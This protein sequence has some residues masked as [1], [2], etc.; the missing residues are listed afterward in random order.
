MAMQASP[1]GCTKEVW[2]TKPLVEPQE[3][4]KLKA[5]D[6]SRDKAP[7]NST[8]LRKQRRDWKSQKASCCISE[9]F[10]KKKNQE[11]SVKLEKR[12]EPSAPPHLLKKYLFIWLCRVLAAACGV[13]SCNMWDPTRDWTWASCVGSR[14]LATGSPREAPWA[15]F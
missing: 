4:T 9:C 11:T 1:V 14:V 2:G 6:L 5:R 12:S 8:R 3:L 15:S 7:Q 10:T 13:F